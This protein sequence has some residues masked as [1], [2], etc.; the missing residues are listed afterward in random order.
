MKPHDSRF[1]FVDWE[2]ICASDGLII[3]GL[4]CSALKRYALRVLT[5]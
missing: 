1:T 4:S 2:W 3:G 5:I